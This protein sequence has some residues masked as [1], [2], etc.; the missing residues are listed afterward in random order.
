[1]LDRRHFIKEMA[2]LSGAIILVPSITS[3]S[4]KPGRASNDPLA[5]PGAKPA[6]WDEIA[7]NTKRALAGAAPKSYHG[8]ISGAGGDKKHVG[9]H[10]PYL[11]KIEKTPDGYLAVMFGDESKGYARHPN[12]EANA[13]LEDTGHWY[14]Y[15]TIR[16]ATDD[17]AEEVKSAYSSWPK[18]SKADNGQYAVFSGKDIT[19]NKGK[20][21]VYLAALPKD[22]KK[23]DM[24]RI[25]GHCKNH[26]EWVN[27][28]T[29]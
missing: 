4:G 23:G 16:K 12:S 5:L 10:L 24:I 20:E 9:K 1:M 27:Y 25:A 7:F 13:D 18:I 11:P 21:T 17:T 15:I 14:D 2:L 6:D 29:L 8:A 22:V 26:G 3:C 19:A 28:F